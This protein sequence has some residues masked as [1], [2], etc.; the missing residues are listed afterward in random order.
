M[1]MLILMLMLASLV[2]TGLNCKDHNFEHSTLYIIF[3]Y[4]NDWKV[5]AVCLTEMMLL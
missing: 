3:S 4:Y 1:L 2:R 5:H